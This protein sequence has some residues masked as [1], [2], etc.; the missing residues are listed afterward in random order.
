M[1]RS[2]AGDTDDGGNE[3][4]FL[5]LCVVAGSRTGD[6]G[7]ACT[8]P[9]KAPGVEF[10]VVS[11]AGVWAAHGARATQ[12]SSKAMAM[13]DGQTALPFMTAPP[14]CMVFSVG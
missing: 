1:K 5:L 4:S 12:E 10:V 2:M 9:G 13:V 7:D 3:V 11:E 6:D 14:Q 8:G